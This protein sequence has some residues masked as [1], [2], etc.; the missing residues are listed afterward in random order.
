MSKK[1][2]FRVVTRAEDGS[3]RIR[4]FHSAESI[5]R[6]HS[7]IGIDDSSTD[8][9]LRGM[10]VFRGLIGPIPEGKNIARYESPEVFELMTKE[11]A[12]NKPRRRRR[13]AKVD[14]DAPIDAPANE[15]VAPS[16]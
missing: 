6:T 15:W 2:V 7:Q 1:D 14:S 16:N 5:F 13:T 11:W 3:I 12:T 9:D 4:D 8:L 10:P